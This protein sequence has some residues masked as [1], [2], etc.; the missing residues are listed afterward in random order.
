ML[1]F[2]LDSVDQWLRDHMVCSKSA[3]QYYKSK[4]GLLLDTTSARVEDNSVEKVK[5]P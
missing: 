3:I 2:S 1:D 5:R 4:Y